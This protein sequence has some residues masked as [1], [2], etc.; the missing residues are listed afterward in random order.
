MLI[1]ELCVMRARYEGTLLPVR[2]KINKPVI[3][4]PSGLQV[5][6]TG[7]AV[8][9]PPDSPQSNPAQAIPSSIS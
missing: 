5:G 7:P 4:Y 9:I 1:A 8:Y 2:A 6:Y 3:L